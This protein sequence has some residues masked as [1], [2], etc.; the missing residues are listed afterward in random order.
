MNKNFYKQ[1]DTR[2]GKL[3]YPGGGYT[4]ASSG[5]GCLSV[6]HCIIEEEKYK[7]YTPKD[8]RK[9][10]T[11]YATYGH[12][13]LWKGIKKS[14]EH[15][16]YT[17]SWPNVDKTMKSA[18]NVLNGKSLKRGVIL[19]GSDKGPD[20]TVWTTG[21]HY[22]SFVKY[23]YE[24]KK[25]WFYLKDSGSR[26]HN[27]WW[28]Y[29]TSMYGDLRQIW[30]CTDFNADKKVPKPGD[31]IKTV[32][33]P[34]DK[35][36]YTIAS[37]TLIKGN[38][39]A[40]VGKLQRFL[41]W[42]CTANMRVDNSFGDITEGYLKIFQKTEGLDPDGIYGNKS[43]AKA[44]TYRPEKA[45]KVVIDV[46][47]WQHNIDW[48]KASKQIDGA[49]LRASYTGQNGFILSDDSTFSTNVK[50]A[51]EYS[52]PIGAYHYSQA[53][54][55]AEAKKEAEHICKKIMP[56]KKKITLPVVCDWEFGKRL[57]AKKAKSLGKDKCTNIVSAFCDVVTDYG[58]T[59]MVY[60]NYSTF[61]T[62]LDYGKL[63]KKYLIWLAQYSKKAS[64]DYDYWQYTSSGSVD[65][66]KGKV[67]MNKA[68]IR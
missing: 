16:G 49:I 25:H 44:K 12:G 29:E 56:Y 50:G 27:K 35:Y 23:K 52:V 37:P 21:G 54:T 8:V 67:D 26:N 47:Y 9:F 15:Y 34:K 58:F 22:I 39:N 30:I 1:Y 14:L 3:P 2:W 13:T 36:G 65:G 28:C 10:M 38:K 6:T 68:V 45:T 51:S 48:K 24:N 53:I 43:Y 59:P 64:L 46:S 42:Y 5:C 17:V 40:E 4:V 11:Q 60:A 7:D 55:V 41:N 18:W 62:Y 20:K 66:I 31:D 57:N 63:K 32:P 33:K 19:F 61:S